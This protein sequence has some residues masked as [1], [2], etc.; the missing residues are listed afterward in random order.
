MDLMFFRPSEFACKCGCGAEAMSP[1][2]LKVLDRARVIA[3][4][5]IIVNSGYRCREHNRH[6][7]GVPNSWHVD[8]RAADIRGD[9]TLRIEQWLGRLLYGLMAA[10]QEL[11]GY[12]QVVVYPAHLHVELQLE[13]PHIPLAVFID[14]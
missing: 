7:G 1:Q 12:Y 6:V 10:S 8:G 3:A 2:F 13:H 9:S 14:R 11:G 5:P 4:V